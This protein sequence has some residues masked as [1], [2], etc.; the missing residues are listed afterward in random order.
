MKVQ[1][2]TRVKVYPQNSV[3]GRK[4][5]KQIPNFKSLQKPKWG[6]LEWGSIGE[7]LL[8]HSNIGYDRKIN[9]NSDFTSPFETQPLL[10]R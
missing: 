8:H 7:S 4:G 9:Q 5:Q 6:V 10:I 1:G 2:D 3:I